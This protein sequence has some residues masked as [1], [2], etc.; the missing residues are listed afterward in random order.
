MELLF[1]S[2]FNYRLRNEKIRLRD[3]VPIFNYGLRNVE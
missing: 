1:F 3:N 2:M